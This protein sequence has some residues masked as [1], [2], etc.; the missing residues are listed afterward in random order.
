VSVDTDPTPI[1]LVAS[2]TTTAA[3]ATYRRIDAE[4][5][6]HFP[7]HA[8]HW[9]YSSRV[10]RRRVRDHSG[11]VLP[12]PQAVLESLRRDGCR[13]AVVQS[14]HLICG[15]EFHRLVWQAAH[16]PLHIHLGLPLLAS[17]EDFDALLE[18][19]AAVRPAAEG[20]ALVLVGHGTA[21]PAWMAYAVLAQRLHERF[22]ETVFLGQVKG[23]P[24]PE[25]IADRLAAAGCRR[26][27]LRP[28][29]LVAGAHFMQDIAGPQAA[30]WQ[31]RLAGRGLEVSAA[32]EGLGAHAIPVGIFCRHIAAAL[33]GRPLD[34]A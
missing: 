33:A 3:S 31:S 7:E 6:R 14:L 16:S 30:S 11:E 34:L 27:H 13:R 22:G 18:W 20:E 23:R 2:G 10:I 32:A 5:R 17:P 15:I 1:V 12:T 26:V 29:M 19:V 21:H 9:A 8:I 4:C 24:S 28:F 25:G